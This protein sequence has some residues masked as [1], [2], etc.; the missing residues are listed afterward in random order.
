MR[1][2][3]QAESIAYECA[4]ATITDLIAV[5]SGQIAEESSNPRP[6][7]VRLASSRAERFRLFRE[8]AGLQVDDHAHIDHIFAEYGTLVRAWRT[9]SRQGITANT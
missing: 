9:P 5:L 2:W 8:R 3:T 7:A 1:E 6:N 4:Q